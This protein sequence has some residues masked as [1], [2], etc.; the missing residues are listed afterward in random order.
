MI[1]W[2][3]TIFYLADKGDQTLENYKSQPQLQITKVFTNHNKF[4][5]LK[6]PEIDCQNI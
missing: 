2:V 5:V 6:P 3:L 1:T 4:L